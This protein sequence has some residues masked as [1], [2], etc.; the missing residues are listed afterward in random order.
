MSLCIV[1]YNDQR[2]NYSLRRVADWNSENLEKASFPNGK[3][4]WLYYDNRSAP[5]I[6]DMAGFWEWEETVQSKNGEEKIWIQSKYLDSDV[7]IEV[8]FPAGLNI[9]SGIF[10]HVWKIPVKICGPFLMAEK[11]DRAGRFHAV[12]CCLEDCQ[13]TLTS[14][15]KYQNICLKDGIYTLPYFELNK[16]RDIISW[17]ESMRGNDVRYFF[18]RIHLGKE[19]GRVVAHS[20]SQMIRKEMEVWL[21]GQE[22]SPSDR[23]IFKKVIQMIPPKTISLE[24]QEKYQISAKESEN[25]IQQFIHRVDTYIEV[26]DSDAELIGNVILHHPGLKKAAEEKMEKKWVE[27]N[28]EKIDEGEKICEQLKQREE[29]LKIQIAQCQ[30][31]LETKQQECR[32]LNRDIDQYKALGEEVQEEAKKKIEDIREHMGKFLSDYAAFTAMPASGRSASTKS[33]WILRLDNDLLLS[34]EKDEEAKTWEDMLDGVIQNLVCSGVASEWEELLGAYLYAAYVRHTDLLLA[35]PHGRAI[36]DALAMA[37]TGRKAPVLSCHGNAGEAVLEEIHQKQPPILAV[38]NPFHP[39]WLSRMMDVKASCPETLFLW[40]HP[41]TEDLAVEPMGLYNYVL[42]VFTECFVDGD[43]RPDEMRKM[44]LA[45]SFAAY[46][47]HIEGIRLSGM[48]ELRL[49]PLT[50]ERFRNMIETA[51]GMLDDADIVED[52]EFMMGKIPFAVLTGKRHLL[53]TGEGSSREIREA[54][55]RYQ[56]EDEE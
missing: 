27:Y 1:K 33:G 37:V 34:G 9:Q 53:R 30:K 24:L 21:K 47:G 44:R 32:E 29:T 23:R 51:G 41:F 17:S 15:N 22:V 2:N 7:P 18:N 19:K 55:A 50:A 40:L 46:E 5:T 10:D 4:K 39:E 16:N 13:I 56:E 26:N 28:R 8:W 38:E 52:M 20:P 12:L 31:E 45:E 25:W 49:S 6:Q 54:A 35:G 43:A 42:P 3:Y 11:P 36:A 14:D 48:K